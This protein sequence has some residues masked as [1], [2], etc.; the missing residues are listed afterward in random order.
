MRD[1]LKKVRSDY[2]AY[3][4]ALNNAVLNENGQATKW[5]FEAYKQR[6]LWLVYPRVEP[7]Y[8]SF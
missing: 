5:L 2:A 4:L 3:R 6:H 8:D 1:H 7:V